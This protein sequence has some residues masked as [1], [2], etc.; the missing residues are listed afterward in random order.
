MSRLVWVDTEGKTQEADPEPSGGDRHMA[1]RHR[2]IVAETEG[3]SIA[4]FP[5]PHQYFF[6]RDLTDNQQTVWYGR[7]HRGLDGRYGF[8][9]RQ[10][11]RGGGS[12]VPWF[13]A[14]PGTEQRLGMFLLLTSRNGPAGP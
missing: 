11:E 2:T 6:P 9:I 13:N 8:G 7:N 12:Y 14:P 5:P 3:G 4:C 10:T 1:V